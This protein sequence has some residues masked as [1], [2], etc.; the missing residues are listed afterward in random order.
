MEEQD[1]V[2]IDMNESEDITKGL[3]A[4]T[5]RYVLFRETDGI[6]LGMF[7]G[8]AFWSKLDPVG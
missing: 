4:P 8:M 7:A 1:D 5:Y 2:I 6:Y 3:P